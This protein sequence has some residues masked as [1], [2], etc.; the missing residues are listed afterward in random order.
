MAG[1]NNRM[2][3]K[4]NKSTRKVSP[5]LEFLRLKRAEEEKDSKQREPKPTK[6]VE[7]K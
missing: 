3:Q 1:A 5:T 4:S 6:K 7:D 2:V